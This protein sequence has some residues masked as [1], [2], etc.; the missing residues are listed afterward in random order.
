VPI[1]H[2]IHEVDP[3]TGEYVPGR[4]LGQPAPETPVKL[5]ESGLVGSMKPSASLYVPEEHLTQYCDE[6]A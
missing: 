6:L 4:H 2:D 1:G 3:S 5:E